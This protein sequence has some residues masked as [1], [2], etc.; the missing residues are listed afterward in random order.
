MFSAGVCVAFPSCALRPKFEFFVL[1]LLPSN[2]N[3]KERERERERETQ[4]I[5]GRIDFLIHSFIV[6]ALSFLRNHLK[7]W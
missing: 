7:N 1:L 3:Q 2:S 4:K 6:R 5:N